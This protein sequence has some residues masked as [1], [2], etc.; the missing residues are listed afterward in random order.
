[1]SPK[2][3][4]DIDNF[5]EPPEPLDYPEYLS[6]LQK[7]QD[8]TDLL[9]VKIRM[10][11]RAG[12]TLAVAHK[13][14]DSAVL[15]SEA[16]AILGEQ[17]AVDMPDYTVSVF[18]LEHMREH[19]DIPVIE[20]DNGEYI[21]LTGSEATG[22][23]ADNM[24]LL[25][26]IET[27]STHIYP[28]S[29]ELSRAAT[30]AGRRRAQRRAAYAARKFKRLVADHASG[31]GA[32][33]INDLDSRDDLEYMGAVPRPGH[34]SSLFI[35]TAGGETIAEWVKKNVVFTTMTLDNWMDWLAEFQE[36][37]PETIGKIHGLPVLFG[38]AGGM[39]CYSAGPS[40]PTLLELHL[41]APF[42][43]PPWD[44]EKIDAA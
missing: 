5:P 4:K 18:K 30:P 34:S 6:E 14:D 36:S 27:G 23:S 26:D 21:F 29:L 33:Y 35:A 15:I 8:S 41:S 24:Q 9:A 37:K 10:L 44:S 12:K 7:Q 1:M 13:P 32:A 16:E 2:K 17:V 19:R 28:F 42:Y 31:L 22:I 38:A 43:P 3:I 40:A 20:F 11:L 39:Y 25:H